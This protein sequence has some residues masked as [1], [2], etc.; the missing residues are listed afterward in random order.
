MVLSTFLA[1]FLLIGTAKTPQRGILRR[2]Q[3]WKDY[4]RLAQMEDYLLHDI[5]L[6]R[7]QVAAAGQLWDAPNIGRKR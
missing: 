6:T 1:P 5:G 3:D 7:D 2:V 4:R